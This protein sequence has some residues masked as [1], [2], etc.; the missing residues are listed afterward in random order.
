[1]KIPSGSFRYTV[2]IGISAIFSVAPIAIVSLS[3]ISTIE[4]KLLLVINCASWIT[5]SLMLIGSLR[6]HR[7]IEGMRQACGFDK[8]SGD[9]ENRL[10]TL[11]DEVGRWQR[12]SYAFRLKDTVGNNDLGS[13]LQRIIQLAY[14]ELPTKAVQ[15][16][17]FEDETGRNSKTMMMGDPSGFASE[18]F[19]Y[20]DKE[21]LPVIPQLI[22]NGR[23]VRQS[24]SFAGSTFGVFSAEVLPG[25]KFSNTDLQ[26][27]Y[28][29]AQQGAIMLVNAKFTDELIKLKRAGEESLKVKTGFLANLSHEIR[30]PLGIILNG[31][32][33]VADGL[34]GPVNSQQTDTLSM[35]K[36]S[37]EH[38]LDLVNDVL[39]YAKVESGKIIPKKE[40]IAVGSILK[41][42]SKIARTQGI[43]KKQKVE[44]AD[45]SPA[46]GVMCDKRHL[47]QMMINLLTNAVKYTPEGGNVLIKA[48]YAPHGRIKI[49]VIDDGIGISEKNRNSVFQAFERVDDEYALEQLGTGLGMPLTKRLAEVNNGYVDFTSKVGEGSTFWI[50]LEAVAIDAAEESFQDVVEKKEGVPGCGENVILADKDSEARIL[51]SKY[52]NSQGF[53]IVEVDSGEDLLN[54]LNSKNISIAVIENN[55]PDISSDKLLPQIRSSKGG[56]K[57][58]I[59]MVSPDAFDFNVEHFIRLG[60]DRCL[61]KPINLAEL[62]LVVRGMIDRC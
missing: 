44:L 50:T 23:Q 27:I 47:R 58:P 24:V 1:M 31:I 29:L 53:N 38:L 34:C 3:E 48:E 22:E 18:G 9:L 4:A 25:E 11:L 14:E 40:E 54:A 49:S 61:S 13:S 35:V 62:T 33:L 30:G 51:V 12:A 41:D 6:M 45:V 8:I 39:D 32:E 15:L 59:V 42:L 37:G 28:L 21:V 36:R 2:L 60:A 7:M 17:L 10:G 26:V 46:M 16:V 20:S 57:I 56:K 52:L 5:V 43:A 19:E 55:L